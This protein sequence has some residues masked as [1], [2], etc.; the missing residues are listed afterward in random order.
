MTIQPGYVIL[1]GSGETAPSMRKV[2]NWLFSQLAP[3]PEVCVL[4]T[5][6][7]FEPNSDKVA[8]RVADFFSHNLQNYR[9]QTRVI[10][11]RKRN[12]PFSPNDPKIIAPLRRADVIFMGPGSP[13][14][15]VRQLQDT[16]A[17]HMLVA[18]HRL[19][20]SLI[21]ASATTLAFSAHTLPVYEIYKVGEELHWHLG[22]DFFGLYG[23]S[24]VLVPHWNNTEGGAELDTSRCYMGQA[25]FEKLM[26]MLP[27]RQT[28]VG[29]SEHTAL[30][31]DP[32]A[33]SCRVMG[34]GNVTLIR[35][36]STTRFEAGQE[37]AITEL[38]PFR[39]PAPETIVPQS[40]WEQVQQAH[41]KKQADAAPAPPAEVLA[42][43][44]QRQ[45][46][47]QQQDWAT[48]DSLRNEIAQLGWQVYDTPQGPQ[49][50]VRQ[51][52]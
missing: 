21:L 51:P 29:I 34:L 8:Q 35:G 16:L 15:A 23:L 3:S 41:A 49:L 26:A 46:A 27:P 4:E 2:Y 5:P 43:V 44:K 12:T 20:A 45:S 40:V 13:T 9:P 37:F 11:A 10:P 47:R 38:G 32:A 18:R 39:S 22:L 19:G 48:A 33:Q 24:L 6:A 36:E 50:E 52:V 1:L 7:G 17:W 25:R 42:L 30:L 28:V 31:L 14:Y